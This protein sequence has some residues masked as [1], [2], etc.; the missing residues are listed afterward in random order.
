[1]CF[2]YM[3]LEVLEWFADSL[4]LSFVI[5]YSIDMAKWNSV[6]NGNNIKKNDFNEYIVC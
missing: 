2:W 1:M 6:M 5:K 4:L 3:F